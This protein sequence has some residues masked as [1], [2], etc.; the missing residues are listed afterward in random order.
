M[1]NDYRRYEVLLP[2]RFNDGTPVPDDLIAQTLLD[3]EQQFGAVSS[4]LAPVE[5]RWRYQGQT[6]VDEL[7]RVFVDVLDAPENES[8]FLDF[9]Q[10]LLARFQQI[11]I[12]RTAYPIKVL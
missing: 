4:D 7:A 6:C 9:K 5:G 11:D 12:W 8:F 3:L 1:S 2:R 10:S